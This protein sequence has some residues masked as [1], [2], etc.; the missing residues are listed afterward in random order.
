MIPQPSPR[1]LLDQAVNAVRA[2][3]FDK[4]RQTYETVLK[5]DPQNAGLLL[6]LARVCHEQCDK[7]ACETY[8]KAAITNALDNAELLNKIAKHAEE[9]GFSTLALETYTQAGKANPKL[10]SPAADKAH[11]L[12]TL[13]QFD[14]S[15]KIFRKLIKKH[16]D[17]TELYRVFIL[18][19]KLK[20]GDPLLRQMLAL[21]KDKR[22]TDL[23]RMHLGFA[24]AKAM[25]DSG[26]PQH[27]FTFLNKANALQKVAA[28]Y[29]RAER[30]AEQAMFMQAQHSLPAPRNTPDMQV[31]PI[32]VAGMPRSGTTLIEQTI[33]RHSLVTAGGELGH[34]QKL[35]PRFLYQDGKLPELAD[36]ND[37]QLD[38]WSARTQALLAR[39]AQ[40]D[41]DF[42]TDKAIMTFM[43]FG[44]IHHAMPN[45][46]FVVVHRDPRD[47]ALSIY[48]NHFKLGNHR[49]GSDLADIAFA[50]KQFR[51]YITFWRDRL[52]GVI[53]E[54]RYEEF[55]SDPQTQTRAL[56]DAIGLDWEDACL[57]SG[58]TAG[59]VKTLSLAQVRQPI[60]TGRKE[61]WRKYEQEMQ[62]FIDAWGDEPWD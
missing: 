45:A 54:V 30:E 58:A 33:A 10:I 32:F 4:A 53:H 36:L 3:D 19:K 9:F 44:A 41:T 39:D 49:Y 61:A 8:I 5:M 52:P 26:Q 25:E 60:H 7:T 2:G 18:A 48:R 6:T 23:A 59:V 28:P 34:A 42:V 15:E 31:T 16:P 20:K 14:E 17:Q 51:Q 56:I 12:Q 50:I 21:W 38:R 1:A 13:G 47:T 24:L 43:L 35:A 55:V 27:V 57:N 37:Q 46:R 29:D 62:P 22:L 11:L 40:S